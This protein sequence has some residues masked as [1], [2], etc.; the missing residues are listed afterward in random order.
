[1]GFQQFFNCGLRDDLLKITE[2]LMNGGFV[3]GEAYGAAE[4]GP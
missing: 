1:M 4:F 3:P 2:S